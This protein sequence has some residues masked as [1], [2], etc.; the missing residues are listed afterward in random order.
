[1]SCSEHLRNWVIWTGLL[2][3]AIWAAVFGTV[4]GIVHDPDHRPVQGAEVVVK[5]SSSDYVQKLT[6][7]AD[8]GF[9]ASPT[10]RL[11]RGRRDEFSRSPGDLVPIAKKAP[12]RSALGQER[13][14]RRSLR[15]FLG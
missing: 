8:G 10:P 15:S 12:A 2:P 7:N 1:M 11:A 13:E 14:P 9:E 6:T 4:R 3:V 5:S